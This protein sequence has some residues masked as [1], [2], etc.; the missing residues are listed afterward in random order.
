MSAEDAFQYQLQNQ[1]LQEEDM[2]VD[3]C[4]D[5]KT[6]IFTKEM[7]YFIKIIKYEHPPKSSS[8]LYTIQASVNNINTL[9]FI[10]RNK[11]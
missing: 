4:S 6:K 10:I 9:K 2:L 11:F 1:N 8:Y 7:S 3:R 5:Y